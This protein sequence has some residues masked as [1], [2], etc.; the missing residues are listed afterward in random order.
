MAVQRRK[1]E[2]ILDGFVLS[3][4]STQV[5]GI[6][7][8][9]LLMGVEW[10]KSE[11]AA[12]NLPSVLSNASCGSTLFPTVQI[13]TIK[14][15]RFA[16]YGM[17][18][19]SNKDLLEKCTIENPSTWLKQNKA[20]ADAHIV[21]ADLSSSEIKDL[22]SESDLII[23]TQIGKTT[24]YPQSLS[25]NTVWVGG[26]QKGKSLVEL[27]LGMNGGFGFQ[28]VQIQKRLTEDL[29][30]QNNRLAELQKKQTNEKLN[31][32]AHKRYALQINYSKTK[33]EELLKEV[34]SF[35]NSNVHA[36]TITQSNISLNDTIPDWS[37]IGPIVE[38]TNKDITI[39]QNQ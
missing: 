34:E 1:V 14:Q 36:N 8:R 31:S 24:A 25:A 3:P 16:F 9:D 33:I 27:S 5:L 37:P 10:L 29:D 12:R 18:S 26:G 30:R 13:V 20:D 35:Q 17:L 19:P 2:L 32:P 21:F 7:S 38:Q 28:D 23:E 11:I 15:T 6:G 22:I 39:I 4:G